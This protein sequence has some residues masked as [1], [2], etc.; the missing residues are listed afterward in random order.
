VVSQRVVITG[1]ASGIGLATSRAF[2]AAGAQVVGIDIAAAPDDVDCIAADLAD[3]SS[4]ENSVGKAAARLGGIDCLVNSAGVEYDA[5]L[6]EL[7][8][9]AFDKMIAINL[10]GPVLVTRA[11]LPHF[12]D[13]SRIINI[14][15]EL[16]FLG[17]A[18][19]S[20]Y[21]ATKGAILSLTRSWAREL[22]PRILVNAVAPGPIDTPLLNFA[23]MSENLR[24][25]EI[26][27]PLGRIGKPEEVA[28]MILFLAG[29]GA[30]FITGQCFSVDGG[31]AMH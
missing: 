30:S 8:I 27:N 18:G 21:C 12:A 13:G 10:R 9:A 2:A 7:D 29:P 6:A 15:S 14:A 26:S 22:G 25:T 5:M 3:S 19:A 24:K 16:G 11:A 31:A 23:G 20:G 28:A 17:R 4:V 1:A